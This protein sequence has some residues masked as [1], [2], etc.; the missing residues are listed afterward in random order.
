MLKAIATLLVIVGHVI[1]FTNPDFDKSVLFKIIYSFHMPLFMCISGYLMPDRVGPRFLR[2]K[3]F[4]LVI[5]FFLWS[6]MLVVVRNIAQGSEISW[7]T[8]GEGLLQ[9]LL[10]PE[11]GL[12][13]LWV[14]FL[15]CTL[16]AFLEGRY[17]M[18]IS[19]AV[20]GLLYLIQFVNGEFCW[21]GLNLVRWHYLFFVFGFL[22]RNNRVLPIANKFLWIIAPLTILALA[23]WERNLMTSFLGL[24]LTSPLFAKILTLIVKYLAAIGVLVL[25]FLVKERLDFSGS[26]ISFL[27]NQSL[28][29]YGA[30]A[31]FLIPATLIWKSQNGMD[32]L[33]LFTLTVIVCS[34][35]VLIFDRFDMTRKL[36]LGRAQA[37][38]SFRKSQ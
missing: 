9:V 32:Q 37:S 8:V 34:V 3:F 7:Q 12:W 5:P 23:Q 15:N 24:T 26:V 6:A 29:Y 36:F 19:F 25:V 17:R 1:Q 13:F 35:V 4:Q 18:Q 27:A 10:A 38:Q 14:L 22:I 20:I 31:V 30:Q 21:F 11:N 28:G 2:R 33:A 16:F